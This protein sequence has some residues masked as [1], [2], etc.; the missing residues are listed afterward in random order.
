MFWL[1]GGLRHC[2]SNSDC[3]STMTVS[4]K[5]QNVTNVFMTFNF[6]DWLRSG[7]I[8]THECP[9]I[10]Q[11]FYFCQFY[12]DDVAIV[13]RIFETLKLTKYN[14]LDVKNLFKKYRLDSIVLK[15]LI[16]TG[17]HYHVEKKSSYQTS[18]PEETEKERQ[19]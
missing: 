12:A 9:R 1:I 10:W 4:I 13:C 14:H 5:H 15:P 16:Y 19:K 17:R 8:R 2:Q 11:L 18:G 7:E 3:W 6:D